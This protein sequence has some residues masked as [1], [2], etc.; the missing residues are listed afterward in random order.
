MAEHLQNRLRAGGVRLPAQPRPDAER[1]RRVADAGR[2]AGVRAGPVPD[3]RGGGAAGRPAG[4]RA[5]GEPA[6]LL[7]VA[8]ADH[9]GVFVGGV[10]QRA[11]RSRACPMRRWRRRSWRCTARSIGN[12]SGAGW[13]C[14]PGG[15]R[16]R[17]SAS[18]RR[19]S[20]GIATIWLDGFHALPDPGAA[21]HRGAGAACG[22]DAGDRRGRSRRPRC[23]AL[24]T[25]VER[26]AEVA[27]VAG[28]G[29]R[30]GAGHRA[31][32]RGDRA[33]HSSSRARRDG[34]FARWGSSCGRRS[35]YV[36]IL[37]VDPR[38]VRHSGAVLLRRGVGAAS[39]SP[40]SDGRG[41]RDARRVG[42]RGDSRGDAAGAGARGFGALDR[43]DFA[44]REQ[45]PNAGWRRCGSSGAPAGRR[46]TRLAA[47]RRVAGVRAAAAGL[48]GARERVGAVAAARRRRWRKRPRL[49]R[50][51]ARSR[52]GDSGAR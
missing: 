26:R 4:V 42:P 36:P 32:M 25:S 23:A 18:R 30:A 39:R 10:R 50:A 3:C 13:C 12:W 34:R 6:G 9:R 14:A 7:R 38:A 43:F 51:A 21:G 11:A 19:D 49:W 33:A 27:A 24:A 37:R 15:W 16:S 8:G 29:D 35:A 1:L 46:S 40:L 48:G 22:C 17:R 41:R 31:G 20:R 45:I 47:H 52:F 28:G 2:A 5:G 44:V